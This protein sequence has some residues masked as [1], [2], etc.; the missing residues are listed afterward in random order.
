MDP[1]IVIASISGIFVVASSGGSLGYII[2]RNGKDKA[3]LSGM[4]EQKVVDLTKSV[5]D[6]K[7]EMRSFKEQHGKDMKELREGIGY[8]KE[9]L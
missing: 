9:R 7:V 5:D 1:A 6:V 8:C 4:Y 3:R 2:H